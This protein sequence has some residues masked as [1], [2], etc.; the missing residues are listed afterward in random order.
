[1]K[2]TFYLIGFICLFTTS[3]FPQ[4]TFLQEGAATK[5]MVLQQLHDWHIPKNLGYPRL[6]FNSNTVNSLRKQ[7]KAG[8]PRIQKVI[9]ECDSLI[10]RPMPDYSNFNLSRYKARNEAEKLSFGYA[11][12]Q[13]NEYSDY[14]RNLVLQMTQWPDWVYDEHKPRR[15]DLGVAGVAYILALCYDWLYPTLTYIEKVE[16]ENSIIE[17]ALV[18][19]HDVYSTKSE[20]WT[21]AEHNWRSVICGEM[22][23]VTLILLEDA[24]NVKENLKFAI[25]GVVDVFTHG[26]KSG[27]WN[28][29]VSYWG[30]GIGQAMMF[31]EALHKVS[32]GAMDL[33]QVPFLKRTGD[34][35]F[36]TRTPKGGSFN[37]SDCNPGPPKPW[38]MAL[39]ASHFKNKNWQW[40]AQKDLGNSIPDILF[41]NADLPAIKPA[42]IALGKYFQGIQVATMRSSWENDAVFVGFK[43]GQ[44]TANHSH[45]DL[46]SFVLHA[47]GNPLLIDLHV[48]PY[49]HYLGFFE[50]ENQR[51]DFEGNH[52]IAHNTLLVNGQGQKHG[53]EYNG[54][55]IN[56]ASSPN[57]QFAV[58]EANTAYGGLL[59]KFHRYITL[60]ENKVVVIVDDVKANGIHQL[61]WLMHYDKDIVKNLDGTFT[62][63]HKNARLDVQFLRPSQQ[64]NRIV[65][66]ESHETTY[67]ATREFTKQTNQFV[68]VQPLHKQQEYRFIVALFPYHENESI[69]CSA[70]VIKELENSLKIKIDH[71]GAA[72]E[73][74]YDFIHNAIE[75]LY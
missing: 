5:E 30:Y 16:I 50:V 63:S 42:N 73:L 60:V 3:I 6:Y 2:Q 39:L 47:F 34:F 26:G 7:F 4:K 27:G 65:S 74:Q 44:T 55:I 46:N 62:V 22:G 13:K 43:T 68:S 36:Y 53:D 31:V 40:S 61:E 33:Y 18:P 23:V 72:Y 37:F 20:G 9:S 70:K 57:F 8:N 1:M 54:R 66:L 28:E 12:T 32:N 48:W 59:D 24:P 25:D 64:D 58:G 67:K 45:L 11:I 41:Y 10:A 35:G 71:N 17:K 19:F 15:V 29:G 38:L 69:T 56:F 14:A 49:A 21:H 52:T 51:W 75:R